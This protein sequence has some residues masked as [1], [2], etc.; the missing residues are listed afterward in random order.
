MR[1][2]DKKRMSKRF[3]T[4]QERLTRIEKAISPYVDAP[5]P[6]TKRPRGAW[7]PGDQI[8]T[9]DPDDNSKEAASVLWR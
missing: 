8:Q 2:S 9:L 1:Q 4:A 3:H 5:T 7:L 6:Q